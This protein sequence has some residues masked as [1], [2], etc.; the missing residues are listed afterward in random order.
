VHQSSDERIREYARGRSSRVQVN[1]FTP[2]EQRMTDSLNARGCG[3][4]MK[5]RW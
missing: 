3:E 5:R 1:F 2:Q 4:D